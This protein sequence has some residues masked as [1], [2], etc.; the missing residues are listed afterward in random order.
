M[1]DK[2]KISDYFISLRKDKADFILN[3]IKWEEDIK[4]KVYVF[5][6]NGILFS[7]SLD[8]NDPNYCYLNYKTLRHNSCQTFETKNC[9]VAYLMA[10][11]L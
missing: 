6:Y 5:R 1:Q 4:N 7:K 8:D 9:L 3:K 11:F 2:I 10:L